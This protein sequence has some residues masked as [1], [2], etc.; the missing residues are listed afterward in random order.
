MR[1]V[2]VTAVFCLAANAMARAIYCCSSGSNGQFNLAVEDTQFC[3]SRGAGA[4][5]TSGTNVNYALEWFY[6]GY[7]GLTAIPARTT[8]WY[9]PEYRVKLNISEK[10]EVNTRG[11]KM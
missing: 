5:Q 9:C 8:K 2:V 1:T 10:W 6:I 7:V 3:C 4:F 11:V